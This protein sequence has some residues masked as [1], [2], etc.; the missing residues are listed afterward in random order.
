MNIE[1]YYDKITY[2]SSVYE[3]SLPENSYMAGLLYG[4]DG[5][6]PN[7]ARVLEIGCGVGANSISFALNHPDAK[8]T[9]VDLSSKQIELA[10]ELK[11]RLGVKN[12]KFIKKDILEIDDK[13]GEF[14]YIIA[15][16]VYSWVDDDVKE[17][18]FKIFKECLSKNGIAYLSYNTYPGW[19]GKEILRDIMLYRSSGALH[20]DM[21]ELGFDTL[22]YLKNNAFDNLVRKVIDDNYYNIVGKSSSYILH[23]YFDP[24]NN[25]N[26][27]YEVAN[28]AKDNELN[29]LCEAEWQSSIFP[30]VDEN[31][32]N[33]LKAECRG[34]RVRFE[35]FIDFIVNRTFRMTL[36]TKAKPKDDVNIEFSKLDELFVSGNFIYDS[37]NRVY[38]NIQ[39]NSIM[40]KGMGKLFDKLSE[41]YPSN[42]SVGEFMS[43]LKESKSDE[44]IRTFYTNLAYLLCSEEI[45]FSIY[46][47]EFLK[48]MPKKP[49]LNKNN[50]KIVEFI[51]ERNGVVSFFGP[52]YQ[53]VTLNSDCDYDLLPLMDGT[54]DMDKLTDELIN[55]QKS[56]KF[57]FIIEDR[58]VED[59][60][61]IK[62]MAKEYVKN[63][64]IRLYNCGFL[65]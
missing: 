30:P 40:P 16:G 39:T 46:K 35:Q 41:I 47:K 63:I 52:L 44:E 37:I 58:V 17:K 15:H 13:F 4:V 49:K 24:I 10:N 1:K 26:Y 43:E 9:G 45:N 19:K 18:I 54:R 36:F 7:K 59:E 28:L 60:D 64:V 25:P 14:D 61:K 42:L 23:E 6:L 57:N 22:R 3:A 2:S 50:I 34:D 11:N 5:V 51:K 8:V 31:L 33:A 21:I 53:N 27:F 32:K 65:V 62:S 55:L 20:D 29:F 38:K 12:A 56:G 48:D